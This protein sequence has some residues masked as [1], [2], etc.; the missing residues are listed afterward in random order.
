MAVFDGM[1][2]LLV[3]L[4]NYNLKNFIMHNDEKT[5]EVL[6]DLIL[7][8]NDRTDGY[9]KAIKEVKGKDQ[10][11]DDLLEQM[12]MQSRHYKAALTEEVSVLRGEPIKEG[13]TNSGKVHRVWMDIKAAFSSDDATSALEECEFGEDAAQKAYH[14]ALNT[15]EIPAF[16]HELILKQQLELKD[17]HDLIKEK[18]DTYK[19][20]HA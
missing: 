12:A 13:T 20:A 8:N 7:I 6:N 15:E 1:I 5:I 14:E 18:R 10:L 17:S 11:L 9:A 3:E 19:V 16:L 4:N 2:I